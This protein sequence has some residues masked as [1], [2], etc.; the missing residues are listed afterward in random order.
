M[1]EI[2]NKELLLAVSRATSVLK[3]SIHLPILKCVRITSTGSSVRFYCT[4]LNIS[5]VS[6]LPINTVEFDIAVDGKLL[7][8]ILAKYAD[9]DVVKLKITD[10]KLTVSCG[11][12]RN[13]IKL[14]NVLDFPDMVKNEF[15][16]DFSVSQEKLR[17]SIVRV[18]HAMARGDV[19]PYLNGVT[20]LLD[21]DKLNVIGSD[22]HRMAFIS[23]NI[24]NVNKNIHAIIPNDSVGIIKKI[25]SGDGDCVVSL[26]SN[27]IQI[28]CGNV[29]VVSKLIDSII[30]DYNKFLDKHKLNNSVNISKV[31]IVNAIDRACSLYSKDIFGCSEFTLTNNNLHIN[32]EVK[33]ND[34]NDDIAVDYIGDE[35]TIGLDAR[36]ANDALNSINNKYV[37]LS[38]NNDFNAPVFLE[39]TE[40]DEGLYVIMKKRK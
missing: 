1:I 9:T 25:I 13:N 24:D 39:G 23:D 27:T 17:D 10:D 31:D 12:S 37:K 29:A 34:I 14:A 36:F 19:R 26:N 35:I 28:F 16:V 21:N 20:L 22:G 6:Y 8:N 5:I 33:D 40:T 11:K 38:F 15:T 32:T 18:E 4:N 3:D 30:P 7:R 2:I